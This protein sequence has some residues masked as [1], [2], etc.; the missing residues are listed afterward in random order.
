MTTSVSPA[1]EARGGTVARQPPASSRQETVGRRPQ[2][3]RRLRMRDDP[4]HVT[5]QLDEIFFPREDGVVV[6]GRLSLTGAEALEL[7]LAAGAAIALNRHD[8]GRGT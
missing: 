4:P 3:A 2:N 1:V 8:A 5:G 7:V 6:G